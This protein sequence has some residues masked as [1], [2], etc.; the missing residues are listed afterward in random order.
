MSPSHTSS[1][2]V[3]PFILGVL[4]HLPPS[5]ETQK[6]TRGK[7]V[8]GLWRNW[9]ILNGPWKWHIPLNCWELLA[10]NAMSHARRP[11]SLTTLQ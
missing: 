1:A 9:F 3:T 5:T 2:L 10:C 11:Q 8:Q 7:R 4:L 6:R